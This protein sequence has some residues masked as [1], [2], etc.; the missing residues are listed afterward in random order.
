MVILIDQSGSMKDKLIFHNETISKANTFANIINALL[1][2]IINRCTRAE[3]ILNYIDIAV[4]EY[5][6]K[7]YEEANFA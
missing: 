7:S 6:G 5:G 2:E 3:G 1:N 4:I